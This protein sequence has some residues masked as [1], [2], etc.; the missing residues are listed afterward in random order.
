MPANL[1][2]LSGSD[3]LAV[4]REV[5]ARLRAQNCYVA[6]FAAIV[7]AL[8]AKQ[9]NRARALWAAIPK[10]GMGGLLDSIVDE[11]LYLRLLPRFVEL[12]G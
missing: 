7:A 12:L 2:Y 9:L 3:L 5:L 1:G 8:E 4:A 6:S 10:A 11:E